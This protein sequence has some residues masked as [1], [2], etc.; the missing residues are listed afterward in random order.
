[1]KKTSGLLSMLL[2][3]AVIFTGLPVYAAEEEEQVIVNEPAFEEESVDET[4]DVTGIDPETSWMSLKNLAEQYDETLDSESDSKYKIIF[5]KENGVTLSKYTDERLSKAGNDNIEKGEDG[6]ITQ[7]FDKGSE[8]Q[9]APFV[10]LLDGK[11]AGFTKTWIL[12]WT[13]TYMKEVT[14]G[15]VTGVYVPATRTRT[16]NLPYDATVADVLNKLGSHAPADRIIRL[17]PNWQDP[18]SSIEYDFSDA[19]R[20]GVDIENPNDELTGYTAGDTLEFELPDSAEEGYELTGFEFLFGDDEWG[21]AVPGTGKKAGKYLINTGTNT[22]SLTVIG[23]SRYINLLEG[24]KADVKDTAYEF[25]VETVSGENE[26]TVT[27][28]TKVNKEEGT[29]EADQV[30]ATIT[31]DVDGYES[32]DSKIW[33]YETDD[34]GHMYTGS[35][36]YTGEAIKPKYN[37]YDG[38]R[39]LTEGSDYTVKYS[40]NTN[41][42]TATATLNFKE[43]YK[44][45]AAIKISFTI[46]QADLTADATATDMSIAAT[47]KL[48]KLTPDI[49]INASG[50]KFGKSLFNYTYKKEKDGEY[51]DVDGITEKGTYIAVIEPKKAD[52]NFKGTAEATITVTENKTNLLSQAKVKLTKNKYLYTGEPVTLDPDT[53]TVTLNNEKLVEVTDYVIT[54]DHNTEPGKATVIFTAKPENEKGLVGSKSETFTISKGRELKEQGEGSDFTYSYSTSVTYSKAG[55]KPAVVVKDNGE[56]LKAGTDYTVSY[57]NNKNVAKAG[58]KNKSGK[59]IGPKIVLTGK[60]IYKGKVTLPFTI[61]QRSITT[62]KKGI[63]VEDKGRSNKGYK[64]PLITVKDGNTALKAG[65]EFE[66]DPDSYKVIE[67]GST[68]EKVNPDSAAV[69][70]TVKV[71][72]I[73]KGNYSERITVEYKYLEKPIKLSSTKAEKIK[74]KKYTGGY[75]SLTVNELNKLLYTVKGKNK[76]YLRYKTDFKVVTYQSNRK[77]GTATVYLKGINGY[78][79]LTSVKFK[80]TPKK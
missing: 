62:L 36:T 1:M 77:A 66:I 64:N 59:D 17:K 7:E 75:I 3:F 8:D 56:E 29:K 67:P 69:G 70:S 46:D 68:E 25:D 65:K 37:V 63:S 45:S 78:S 26:P 19:E 73:G 34:E 15:G 58:D 76:T 50:K 61:T 13:E 42:G 4:Q 54:Y 74:T 51:V 57:Q 48:Q 32:V 20:Y 35:H 27:T 40:K 14:E 44:G 80:I 28:V 72:I 5:E 49:V 79:G 33:F 2:A 39:K 23:V 31:R 12:T 60:G 52:G 24:V 38:L 16:D 21:R 55:N 11:T 47:G 6:T 71:D 9:L 41:V 22:S 10:Y 43:G 30:I 53:Y 18:V